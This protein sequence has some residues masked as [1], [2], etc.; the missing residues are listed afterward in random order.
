LFTTGFY[1]NPENP[2]M[3]GVRI[4]HGGGNETIFTRVVKSEATV[5]RKF[6]IVDF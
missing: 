2:E 3:S 5:A 6:E 4:Y 1:W